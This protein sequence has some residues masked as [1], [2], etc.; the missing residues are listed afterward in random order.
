VLEHE[1]VD[2]HRNA[3]VRI[4]AGRGAFGFVPLFVLRRL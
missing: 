4:A 2:D 3:S 1:F